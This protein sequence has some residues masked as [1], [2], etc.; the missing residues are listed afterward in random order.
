MVPHNKLFN[1]L[2]QIGFG[3]KFTKV[4]ESM[5]SN[6]KMRVKIGDQISKEFSYE[7]G[8]R[9]G[10]PTSPLLFNLYIN[11]ILN[12]IQPIDVEGIEDGLKGLIFVDDTVIA[13][14]NMIE[15][16]EKFKFMNG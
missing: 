2:K 15:L 10:C 8:V 1:K 3:S 16:N 13:A 11:D 7:R 9:Q 4:M 12:N 5:Y 14:N 6:T